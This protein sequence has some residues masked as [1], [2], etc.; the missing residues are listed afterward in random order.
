VVALVPAVPSNPHEFTT[1]A[2]LLLL[3]TPGVLTVTI[4]SVDAP[5]NKLLAVIV[6]E[7]LVTITST[8]FKLT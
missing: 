3:K 4:L 8:Y 5:L 6:P 2:I 1:D 7:K